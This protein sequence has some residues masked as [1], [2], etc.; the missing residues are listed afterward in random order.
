MKDK[1]VGIC[2]A[3]EVTDSIGPSWWS[4]PQELFRRTRA[5]CLEV[6]SFFPWRNHRP[7][8]TVEYKFCTTYWV[9]LYISSSSETQL[10]KSFV[11]KTGVALLSV[12][13]VTTEVYVLL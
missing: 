9:Q 6:G 12:S 5:A 7:T 1:P 13:C 2:V 11:K 4:D 10:L 3:E 8:S